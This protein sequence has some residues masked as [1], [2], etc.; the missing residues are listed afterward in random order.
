MVMKVGQAVCMIYK[1]GRSSPRNRFDEGYNETVVL[2]VK[3][4]RNTILQPKRIVCF[5][6]MYQRRADLSNRVL[7]GAP[8][9]ERL[10]VRRGISEY[11]RKTN[12]KQLHHSIIQRLF[13]KRS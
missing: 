11:K 5:L 2:P 12:A 4:L 7:P 13:R 8:T 1:E 6:R 10:L 3:T 9:L